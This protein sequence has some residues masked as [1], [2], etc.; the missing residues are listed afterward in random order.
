MISTVLQDFRDRVEAFIA[1]T[2]MTP[3]G[4]GKLACNDGSFVE[5]LRQGS[6][7]V[8]LSTI[9]KVDKFMREHSAEPD[10]E[11]PLP[12]SGA[13]TIEFKAASA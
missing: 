2:G 11:T 8:R 13:G 10:D 6:R 12:H 4:F 1:R 9:D 5:D 3:S 7:E